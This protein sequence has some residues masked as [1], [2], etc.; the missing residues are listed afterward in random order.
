MSS[1]ALH[2]TKSFSET[3]DARHPKTER[4]NLGALIFALQNFAGVIIPLFE[5]SQYDS[6]VVFAIG[7]LLVGSSIQS[8]D[9]NGQNDSSARDGAEIVAFVTPLESM[10]L[11]ATPSSKLIVVRSLII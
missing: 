5:I 9:I 4:L 6:R 8:V 7:C 1:G 10:V 2:Y 11:A 3:F